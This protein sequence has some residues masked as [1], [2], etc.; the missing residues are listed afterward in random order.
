MKPKLEDSSLGLDGPGHPDDD[1]VP[2]RVVSMSSTAAQVRFAI[3]NVWKATASNIDSIRVLYSSA[4]QG[5][6]CSKFSDVQS[7]SPEMEAVCIDG[8]A[9]VAIFVSDASFAG[10]QDVSSLVPN[11]CIDTD[12][13]VAEMSG[14]TVMF[15]FY[16]PCDANDESW[17]VPGTMC[18]DSQAPSAGPSPIPS[19]APSPSPS[20]G[21]T[22]TAAESICVMQAKMDESSLSPD[23][24]GHPEDNAV[25]ARV[26]SMSSAADEVKFAIDNV[27]G[28]SS[29][30]IDKV[31]VVYESTSKGMVC[32]RYSDVEN[33]TPEISAKCTNGIAEVAAFVSDSSFTGVQDVSSLLPSACSKIVA[34][35]DVSDW[36]LDGSHSAPIYNSGNPNPSF[37]G[38]L[39]AGKAYTEYDCHTQTLCVLVMVKDGLV[40]DRSMDNIWIKDYKSGLTGN[41][42]PTKG[43]GIQFVEDANGSAIGWE[44]CFDVSGVSTGGLRDSIEIH[45]NSQGKTLSTG[46]Q[47]TAPLMSLDLQ[48]ASQSNQNMIMFVFKVPCDQDDT[49][50]CVPGTLC[51]DSSVAGA[52]SAGSASLV[53]STEST[54]CKQEARLDSDSTED[55]KGGMYR[56]NPIVITEQQG[57]SV[58]FQVDQTWDISEGDSLDSL[59]VYYETIGETMECVQSSSSSVPTFTAKCSSDVAEVALFVRDSSFKGLSDVSPTV[60]TA[61]TGALSPGA[62]TGDLVMFFFTIPCN[63]TD[64]SFCNAAVESTDEVSALQAQD[65]KEDEITITTNEII[66]GSIHEETFEKPGDALSWEGGFDSNMDIFGSFLG[67]FGSMNPEAQKVFQMPAGASSA[68]ISFKLYDINGGTAGDNLQLG[69]QN[70]WVDIDLSSVAEQY[71]QDES[72]TLRDRSYDRVAFVVTPIENI[73]VIEI[74]I[75]KRWWANNDN[76][77]PFGFRVKSS[78]DINDDSYGIDDFTVQVDCGSQRRAMDG[79]EQPPVSEPSEEGEDGSYYCKASDYPCGDGMDMVHV[80]HYS[81]RL[82]YQTFCIP[83]EDSEVLRFYGNDYCGPCAGGFKGSMD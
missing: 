33:S 14:N 48:C 24:P 41:K 66:C 7:S 67:R 13:G 60:P 83:E 38:F 26:I 36:D 22:W 61:C 3:D 31:R 30:S 73:Y 77:L 55:G 58:T 18:P 8:K 43:G 4:D 79:S 53:A 39:E 42:Y 16:V 12:G 68:T 82:G 28:S 5:M 11:A 29:T 45:T 81:T 76:K 63:P 56:T 32:S 69:I 59:E 49:S 37:S 75:P 20:A 62:A 15:V 52:I 21:P 46:K 50:W 74:E 19:A 72:I 9:E 44:G 10:V 27:W 40:I 65:D 6:L 25:P 54:A 34:D 78:N 35:G 51:P 23:G 17:C 71:H 70:S 1:A 2:A 64:T 57:T 47:G 80:C